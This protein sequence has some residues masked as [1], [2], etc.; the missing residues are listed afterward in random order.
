M[1]L[2]F[3][4]SKHGKNFKHAPIQKGQLPEGKR[5]SVMVYSSKVHSLNGSCI[6]LGRIYACSLKSFKFKFS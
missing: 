6:N 1:A 5:W 3:E 2:E 4:F